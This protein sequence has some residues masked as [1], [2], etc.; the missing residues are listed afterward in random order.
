MK[1]NIIFFLL[2]LFFVSS[3]SIPARFAGSNSVLP[4]GL[5]GGEIGVAHISST[6]TTNY[7]IRNFSIGAQ[8]QKTDDLTI[9]FGLINVFSPYAGFDYRL[10]TWKSFTFKS[11]LNFGFVDG[12][13][14][15]PIKTS[16]DL[17]E[18]VKYEL[19]FRFAGNIYDRDYQRIYTDHPLFTLDKTVYPPWYIGGDT[20]F[21]FKVFNENHLGIRFGYYWH[22]NALA[23]GSNRIWVISANTL[24]GTEFKRFRLFRF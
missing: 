13:I 9:K 12:V 15:I 7:N 5:S 17:G 24:L 22:K 6:D 16:I 4:A 21:N 23:R 11:G 19:T 18:H 3:C 14:S 1:L 2:T 20:G 10:A 8:I